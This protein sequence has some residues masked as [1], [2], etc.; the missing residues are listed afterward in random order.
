VKSA[1]KVLSLRQAQSG[2]TSGRPMS[3]WDGFVYNVLTMGVIFPWLYVLGPGNFPG[4]N[5][6]LAIVITLLVQL[7]IAFAYCCLATVL[8]ISG[9]DYIYQSRAFGKIGVIAVMAGFV[10]WIL[11]WIAIAGKLFATLGVAPLL[12]SLGTCVYRQD[13]TRGATLSQWGLYAQSDVGVFAISLAVALLAALMLSFGLKVYVR[14]QKWLFLL[15]VAGVFAVVAIFYLHQKSFDSDLARFVTILRTL[16]PDEFS[17]AKELS[18]S[19]T[20]FLQLGSPAVP[21]PFSIWHTLAVVPIV[22]TSLQWSIYSV[23]QNSE[24]RDADHLRSQVRMLVC[25]ALLV[26]AILLLITRSERTA[27]SPELLTAISAAYTE[28]ASPNANKLMD[29]LQPFPT[30]LAMMVSRNIFLAG[31]IALG[32][33]ANCFQIVCNSFIGI[34]RIMVAM[35]TDG[36]LPSRLALHTVKRASRSPNVA[37]WYYFLACIPV[38]AAND[39]IRAWSDVSAVGATIA[40]GSVIV[41][42]SLAATRIP[43]KRMR[44]FWMCSDIYW[45][46]G[47]VIKTFGYV[48]AILGSAVTFLNLVVPGLRLDKLSLYVTMLTAL[49][50]PLV[51]SSIIYHYI[52]AKRPGV[53]R[54]IRQTPEEVRAF[55][56]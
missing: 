3:P 48:G 44:S 39:F 16:H 1:D 25:S 27:V 54:K 41:L 29:I 22:W 4:A 19:I 26:T 6:E 9:G 8:P 14:V 40:G 18:T 32:F 50:L 31:I 23:Q 38:I 43:S 36:V 51:F 5:L 56:D 30:V 34:T 53:A 24:I 45:L 47:Y 28:H 35:S 33:L 20:S 10:V 52:A 37:L 11:Q 49:L 55:F 42:T 13:T 12:F 46:P 17:A 2:P 21:H 15:T 7:P